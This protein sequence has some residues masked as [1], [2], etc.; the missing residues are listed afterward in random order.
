VLPSNF[1]HGNCFVGFQEDAM[2][3]RDRHIIGGDNLNW[4]ADYPHSES[5]F[6]RSLE[7]LDNILADCTGKEKAKIV[8]GNAERIYRLD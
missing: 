2:G 8:G 4:G 5:T 1:F 6:P 3:I 7:I